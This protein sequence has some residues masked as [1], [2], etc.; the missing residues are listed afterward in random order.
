M[1]LL[2][3]THALVWWLEDDERL[4]GRA[5]DLIADGA[6]IVFV[7]AVSIWEIRIKEAL[8]R[9]RLPKNFIQSVENEGFYALDITWSHVDR[10][11][12][13]Q[14]LHKDPFDRILISQSQTEKLAIVTRDEQI[15]RY[16]VSTVW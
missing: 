4:S 5:R 15:R 11:S 3:D 12:S 6:N 14:T 9:I 8:G 10:L 16:D 1:N 13:L 2:L 7:S